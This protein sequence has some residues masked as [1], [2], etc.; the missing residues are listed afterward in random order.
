MTQQQLEL[1]VI[2]KA[3][4]IAKALRTG[5]DVVITTTPGNIVVK[6][7]EYKKL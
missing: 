4:E 7:A 5:K 3:K 1:K 2:E 6:A